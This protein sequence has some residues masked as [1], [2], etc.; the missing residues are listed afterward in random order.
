MSKKI[1]SVITTVVLMFIMIVPA[2]AGNGD[3]VAND[4]FPCSVS[5]HNAYLLGD[6]TLG[7]EKIFKISTYASGSE[8]AIVNRK[9]EITGTAP[10]SPIEFFDG[11]TWKDI[12]EYNTQIVLAND[13]E[14]QVRVVFDTAGVYTIKFTL[15]NANGV[16][17]A[18]SKRVVSIS[19][20]GIALY[21]ENETTTEKITTEEESTTVEETTVEEPTIENEIVISE[22]LDISGFQISSSLNDIEGNM[23]FRTVYQIEDTVEGQAVQEVGLVYGL[24]YGDTP[25]TASDVVY[26][27]DSEYVASYAST[28]AGKIDVVMG[29]SET[30]NYYVR[31]MSCGKDGNISTAAYTSKYYVRVYAK[32]ADGSI[33]YSNECSYT[34]FTIADDLYQSDMISKKS[35]F[36]YVYTKILRYVDSTYAER[37]FNWSGTVIK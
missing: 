24:E 33:V 12:S 13:V 34:I 14:R 19:N 22:D 20:E 11:T 25:I 28:E 1:I 37:D 17:I 15:T 26:G 18:Q 21:T 30:A 2:V 16:Q 5:I 27:S 23:G 10:L 3:N 9:V 4:T 8:G 6:Y 7:T 32:L 31:T 36:D 29:N 35:T